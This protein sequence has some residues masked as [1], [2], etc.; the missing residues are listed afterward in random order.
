M[1]LT[2][3]DFLK[4]PYLRIILILTRLLDPTSR[5]ICLF[6]TARKVTFRLLYAADIQNGLRVLAAVPV[7]F[8]F[9][10]DPFFCLVRIDQECKKKL[11][12][13]SSRSPTVFELIAAV[14]KP[15]NVPLQGFEK[16]YQSKI[17]TLNVEYAPTL[18]QHW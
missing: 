5:F 8:S 9:S 10:D 15:L 7:I 18:G 11:V 6:D 3:A 14:I 2:R 16:G 4:I 1:E 12:Y 17:T 13:L